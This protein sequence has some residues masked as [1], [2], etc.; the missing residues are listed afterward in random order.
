MF[1]FGNL[2]TQ[3]NQLTIIIECTVIVATMRRAFIALILDTVSTMDDD[4]IILYL[5]KTNF[6]SD[7]GRVSISDRRVVY[8]MGQRIDLFK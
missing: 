6:V 4:I 8:V 1:G 7:Y 3:G 2:A 5:G